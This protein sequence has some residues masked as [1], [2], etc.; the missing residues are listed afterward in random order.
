MC[1]WYPRSSNIIDRSNLFVN[2]TAILETFYK[3]FNKYETLIGQ[4]ILCGY[5]CRNRWCP[6]RI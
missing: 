3:H 1:K 2:H 6:Y 5:D 4:W